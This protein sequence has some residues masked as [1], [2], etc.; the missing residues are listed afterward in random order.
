M[1][2]DGGRGG[3]NTR[4]LNHACTPNRETIEIDGRVIVNAMCDTQTGEELLID[5]ALEIDGS[6]THHDRTVYRCR[7]GVFSCRGTML[8]SP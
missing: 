6:M 3:N 2:I 4:W 8:S 7:C 1:V 5:Y